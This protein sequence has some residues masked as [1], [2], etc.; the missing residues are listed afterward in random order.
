[1]D[2]RDRADRLL[3][4]R[5][6]LLST[7]LVQLAGVLFVVSLFAHF[8]VRSLPVVSSTGS[9][10]TAGLFL[11]MFLVATGAAYRNDGVLVSVALAA[12]IGLGFYLPAIAF[13]LADPGEVT[14][15]VLAVGTI[16]S[17]LVGVVGFVVGAGGR[18][19]IE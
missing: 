1:M 14:L 4:G 10:V 12:G 18:R 3:F 17:V 9:M 15:W 8:L 11:S 7:K 2:T 6:V 19:V 13:N 16:S 5:D